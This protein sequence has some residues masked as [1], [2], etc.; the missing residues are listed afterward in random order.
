MDLC[1]NRGVCLKLSHILT[2]PSLPPEV[3]LRNTEFGDQPRENN[4]RHI[5]ESRM[6]KEGSVYLSQTRAFTH[7]HLS[8]V[9]AP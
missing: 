8:Y 6:C 9:S 2:S 4:A 7:H 3:I 1:E 5:L